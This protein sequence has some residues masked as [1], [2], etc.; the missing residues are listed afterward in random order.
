MPLQMQRHACLDSL[1][2]FWNSIQNGFSSYEYSID[3]TGQKQ[4]IYTLFYMA[5]SK[6]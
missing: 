6:K 5:N 1:D 3:N 2:L 4:Y